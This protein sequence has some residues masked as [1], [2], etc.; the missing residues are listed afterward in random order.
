MEVTLSY[1][2]KVSYPNKGKYDLEYYINMTRDLAD[3]RV[4]YLVVKDMLVL[5]TPHAAIIL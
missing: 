2:G 5:L 3:M 1:M 4:H